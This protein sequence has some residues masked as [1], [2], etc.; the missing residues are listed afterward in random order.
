MD[1]LGIIFAL[2]AAAIWG[3]V[4]T[5][6][7]KI[8]SFTTPLTWLALQSV[9]GA[10]ILSPII[11]IRF[12]EISKVMHSGKM[13][14]LMLVGTFLL[15]ILGTYFIFLAINRLGA[16]RANIFEITYP[17]FVVL[18][19]FLILHEKFSISFWVGALLVFLGSFVIIKLA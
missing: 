13:N 19:S 18:F 6:D 15:V 16:A 1:V 14:L 3:I 5:L 10:L 2:V 17:F 9:L 4:Y 8:L 12:N 7:Q 11:A